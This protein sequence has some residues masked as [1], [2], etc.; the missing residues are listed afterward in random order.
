MEALVQG[1]TIRTRIGSLGFKLVGASH[2]PFPVVVA[3][4]I[5]SVQGDVVASVWERD[6]C[7]LLIDHR[8]HPSPDRLAR[9]E[10]WQ[11]A[12]EAEAP[13]GGLF[14]VAD[15]YTATPAPGL[16]PSLAAMATAILRG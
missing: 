3:R 1:S 16:P 9:V 6:V 14:V 11:S 12:Q 8:V 5:C 7:Y 15:T 2:T 4:P 10:L 13:L